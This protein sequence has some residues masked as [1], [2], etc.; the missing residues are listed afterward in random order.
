[1]R[2]WAAHG[3]AATVSSEKPQGSA[4]PLG[5]PPVLV[6]TAPA[7]TSHKYRSPVPAA[8]STE[9]QTPATA[10]VLFPLGTPLGVATDLVARRE[11]I[12]S[13]G[14]GPRNDPQ[15]KGAMGNHRRNDEQ[16]GRNEDREI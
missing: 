6:G 7:G 8:G 14:I 12:L 4:P 5:T 9:E 10:Q 1:M 16:A 15:H 3:G 13:P 2:R 11:E